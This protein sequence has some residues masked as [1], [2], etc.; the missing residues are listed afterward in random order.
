VSATQVDLGETDE[1]SL[2]N[3]ALKEFLAQIRNRV[4]LLL[5]FVFDAD[6]IQRVRETFM[7]GSGIHTSYALEIMDVQ[8]PT[9][10]KKLVM[11]LL[12]GLS[13]RERNERFSMLFLQAKQSPE[14]CLRAIIENEHLSFWVR[15]CAVYTSANFA[16]PIRKG[17]NTM[18]STVEKVLILKTVPMFSQTPDNVLVDVANLLEQVDVSENETIF[19]EGDVGDN[20]YVILDGK[21]RVHNDEHLVNYLGEREVFGEMALLDPE[22]RSASVTALEETRLFRLNQGSFY[23]LMEERPEV[24]MG[25]I[26]ILTARLRNV[27]RDNHQLDARLKEVE[28]KGRV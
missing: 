28:G 14:E 1:T 22:P 27:M 25:I 3:A 6:S 4:L 20:M 10:W 12:E 8:L 2:L 11:P 24:A 18:L 19:R 21:V 16:L 23:K 13:P 7:T 17:D 5:S 26:Q 15:A 9:E